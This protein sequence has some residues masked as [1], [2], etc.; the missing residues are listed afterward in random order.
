M[1][2]AKVPYAHVISNTTAGMLEFYIQFALYSPSGLLCYPVSPRTRGGTLCS[3][4]LQSLEHR[5][6]SPCI[7]SSLGKVFADACHQP[8]SALSTAV[9]APTTISTLMLWITACS[10]G[11]PLTCLAAQA[12]LVVS[13]S[14]VVSLYVPHER[15]AYAC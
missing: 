4:T 7:H 8:L 6:C 13:V 5:T 15:D 3:A 14:L 9:P 10:Q 11:I 12:T 2:T 1:L